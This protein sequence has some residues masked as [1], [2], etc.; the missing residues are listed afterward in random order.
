MSDVTREMALAHFGVKGM[1]WGVRNDSKPGRVGTRQAYVNKQRQRLEPFKRVAEGKG[2]TL[3]K[4]A[5]SQ[6]LTLPE[7]VRGKG[8]QGGAQLR[9][10]GQEAFL[11][12]LESGEAR[13]SDILAM[14]GSIG[15]GDIIRGR[16]RVA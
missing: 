6:Q 13:T 12:R 5:V 9:V 4:V 15:L 7:L 16:K 8:A 11:K 14:Y 1:R 3:D 2:S 10:Q